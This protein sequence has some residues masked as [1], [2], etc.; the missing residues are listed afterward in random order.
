MSI[1]LEGLK[2]YKA[3]FP[4][5]TYV[6]VACLIQVMR[7]IN[8]ISGAYASATAR[9]EPFQHLERMFGPQEANSYV[10]LQYFGIDTQKEENEQFSPKELSNTLNFTDEGK[11]LWPK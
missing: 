4:N 11:A 6:D 2:F 8:L 3:K 10:L 9:E 5:A 7:T 1:A